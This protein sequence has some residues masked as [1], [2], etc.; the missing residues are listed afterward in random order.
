MIGRSMTEGAPWKHILRF[1]MPVLAGSLLQQ[2]YNTADS[3]IVGQ[4]SGQSALS[5]VGTTNS[6]AF[7]F[8]AIAMG[9]SAGNGVDVVGQHL[10]GSLHDGGVACRHA[11]VSFGRCGGQR[12]SICV[13]FETNVQLCGCGEKNTIEQGES[14]CA[15]HEEM[16]DNR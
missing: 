11:D 3:I 2:L 13:W 12:K 15:F 8:L 10:C 14:Q 4:F 16:N 9:F 1:A 6:F 7:L 5:A